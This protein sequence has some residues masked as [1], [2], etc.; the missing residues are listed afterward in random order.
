MA[1]RTLVITLEPP[2]HRNLQKGRNRS[3]LKS[4][5]LLLGLQWQENK[6][7]EDS[8]EKGSVITWY[9]VGAQQAHR[10][11]RP[12]THQERAVSHNL[13]EGVAHGTICNVI[14]ARRDRVRWNRACSAENAMVESRVGAPS[15]RLTEEKSSISFSCFDQLI[16]N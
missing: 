12:H 8:R 14:V 3:R 13:P 11:S 10:K 15:C 9:L 5:G 16:M 2:V 4:P 6:N 7:G 1:L